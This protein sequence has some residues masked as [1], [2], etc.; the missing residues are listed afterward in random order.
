MVRRKRLP[1]SLR[2]YIRQEKARLR[3]QI[4]DSKKQEEKIE[5]IYKKLG[6]KEE[7]LPK[8]K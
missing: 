2:Q 6:V 7:F 5:E 8:R 3:R 4:L 1:K